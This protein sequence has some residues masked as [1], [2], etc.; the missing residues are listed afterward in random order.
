MA[1]KWLEKTGTLEVELQEKIVFIGTVQQCREK[2][3]RVF[4]KIRG[5]VSRENVFIGTVPQ[6]NV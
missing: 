4:W 6:E 3:S 5:R 2:M 1:R